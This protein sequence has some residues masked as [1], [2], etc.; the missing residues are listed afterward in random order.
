[1]A[2]LLACRITDTGWWH[3]YI[4]TCTHVYMLSKK[5]AQEN[6]KGT[7]LMSDPVKIFAR[8]AVGIAQG[9]CRGGGAERNR[10]PDQLWNFFHP[11][12]R[13]TTSLPTHKRGGFR[14]SCDARGLL[15]VYIGESGHGVSSESMFTWEVPCNLTFQ[16]CGTT[17]LAELGVLMRWVVFFFP[18]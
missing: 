17:F 1:M 4:V 14:P 11:K 7:A 13:G 5:H 2:I 3:K 8:L 16:A 18:V 15:V 6:W 12:V 9:L 10:G